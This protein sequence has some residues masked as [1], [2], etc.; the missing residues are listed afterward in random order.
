MSD[1][2]G[3]FGIHRRLFDH[4]LWTEK[5]EFSKAEAW[6]DMIQTARYTES[7]TQ[8]FIDGRLIEWD[9]GQFPA[10]IRF[11]KKRW[12]WKSNGKVL[13]FLELLEKQNM[14]EIET[15]QGQSVITLCNYEKYD[16]K[17][18][19]NGT[20]TEQQR[21]ADGTQTEQ[22]SKKDKKGK[23]EKNNRVPPKIL[24]DIDGFEQTWKD[25]EE[26]RNLIG[27]KMTNLAATRIWNKIQELNGCPVDIL[28]QSIENGWQGVFEIKNNQ[29]NGKENR[30]E[31]YIRRVSDL[32]AD[33]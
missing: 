2:V 16:I 13:R 6:I 31:K 17:K 26:H 3:Y 5:R 14:I 33:D 29:K 18:L 32:I 9:Y 19:D 25:F 21:N 27:K 10:S 22:N 7:K 28:N 20:A 23:K 24:L 15:E 8:D 4:P 12:G 30:T 11:L 1:K